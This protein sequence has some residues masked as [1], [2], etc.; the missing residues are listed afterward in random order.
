MCKDTTAGIKYLRAEHLLA[1]KCFTW[2][3]QVITIPIQLL[4]NQDGA[5]EALQF[6]HNARAPQLLAKPTFRRGM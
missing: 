4:F 6:V 1:F 5:G 3:G 2:I